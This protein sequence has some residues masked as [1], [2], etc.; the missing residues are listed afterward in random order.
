MAPCVSDVLSVA[1]MKVKRLTNDLA[2]TMRKTWN[3][4]Q[5]YVGNP[6]GLN[7]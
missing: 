5:C 4:R 3:Y 2:G 1:I 7:L 6:D